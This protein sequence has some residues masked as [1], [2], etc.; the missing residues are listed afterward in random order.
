MC[1]D[2]L[3]ADAARAYIEW[4]AER[5]DSEDSEL[6]TEG[7]VAKYLATEAGNKAAEDS[8]QALGGRYFHEVVLESGRKCC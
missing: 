4:V 1:L 5:L 8:I 6:Q 2:A 3:G 7:A